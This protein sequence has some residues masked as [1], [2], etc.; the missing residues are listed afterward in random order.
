MGRISFFDLRNRKYISVDPLRAEMDEDCA[1]SASASASTFMSPSSSAAS[2]SATH[3]SAYT[4][5]K[6]HHQH[7]LQT[8]FGWLRKDDNYMNH[9]QGVPIYNAVYTHAYNES[10]TKLFVGGGPL[11]LGLCG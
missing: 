11:Q 3:V 10:G 2:V 4:A 7:F 8:G 6:E 9:F 1:R 5:A